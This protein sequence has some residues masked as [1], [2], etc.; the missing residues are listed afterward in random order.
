MLS[1]SDSFSSVHDPTY[2]KYIFKLKIIYENNWVTM[3]NELDFLCLNVDVAWTAWGTK[4][5]Q[6]Q[7]LGL[8][9]WLSVIHHQFSSN[10]Y[11][12][13]AQIL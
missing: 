4:M 9:V 11:L 1:L 2:N 13:S 3:N 6:R 7:S 5:E 10:I 12:Q 8:L